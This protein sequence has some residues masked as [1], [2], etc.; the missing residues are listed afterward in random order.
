MQCNALF[1]WKLIIAIR[2]FVCMQEPDDTF[3]SQVYI[4]YEEI[5]VCNL[6]DMSGFWATPRPTPVPTSEEDTHFYVYWL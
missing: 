3:T 1:L 5:W 2:F 4:S 6:V